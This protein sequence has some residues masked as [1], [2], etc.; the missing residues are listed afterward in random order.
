[1]TLRDSLYEK[2]SQVIAELAGSLGVPD[3]SVEVP[4]SIEYGDYA[5][6]V[7]LMLAKSLGRSPMDIAEELAKKLTDERWEISVA[8]PGFLNFRFA[9]T[10]RAAHIG[11]II[12]MQDQYGA[13]ELLKGKKVIVE[14]TDPNPFKEFH[15]GHLMSNTIGESISRVVEFSGAEVKRANYQGDVGLH[16]AKAVWAILNKTSLN[17]KK[18]VERMNTDKEKA[19]YFGLMYAM[20]AKASESDEQ[21]QKEVKE[22]NKKI[23]DRSD[24]YINEVYD[25]GRKSS[26]AYFEEIYKLLGTKFDFS[27]F[28]SK[29]G[30]K[31]K[32][33][34]S[35]GLQK[36]VFEQS[37]NAI[38]F[39][40]EKVGLH[41]RVF[42]N[43][44]GLPTYEAKE[45]GLAVEKYE[46]Y[47]YDLALVVTGNEIRE[48]FKVVRAV[49][50]QLRP[51]LAENLVHIPHGMLRL[52]SGKMSSRTGD[53]MRAEDLLVYARVELVSR[54]HEIMSGEKDMW[55]AENQKTVEQ[56]ALGAIKYSILRQSAGKDIIFDFETSL[57]FYG[58]SGPYLQYT[59][60]RARSVLRKSDTKGDPTSRNKT[61][62]EDSVALERYLLYFPDAV[63]EALRTYNPHHIANYLFHLSQKFNSFYAHEKIIGSERMLYSLAVT[64]AVAITLKNGLN[65]L[66][67]ETPEE[68]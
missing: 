47:P 41:T 27:F 51:Q 13:N 29:T 8:P 53:V 49:L 19:A 56:V 52:K 4:E 10:I 38:V 3:F 62:H 59:Y 12:E 25:E 30:E 6:N 33:L 32:E 17:F 21:T 34:V 36:G 35:E 26:L 1:M 68:M 64:E 22:I 9:S 65:L 46:L 58:D 16:V 28:E 54:I 7:A 48:Y 20:G 2:I 63:A 11:T 44:A 61:I 15:I 45:L 23:F 37:D 24:P 43:S 42:I 67:I 14:Y 66:G 55:R 31:G 18:Q 5:T 39:R 60:A 50:Q 40:G 57:S